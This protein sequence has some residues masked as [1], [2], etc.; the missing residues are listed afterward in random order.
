MNVENFELIEVKCSNPKCN[1]SFKILKTDKKTKYHSTACMANHQGK[2]I[3]WIGMEMKLNSLPKEV[4]EY[5]KASNL[6]NYN[7]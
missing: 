5:I 6:T 3:D 7:F 4:Q 1:L 2:T